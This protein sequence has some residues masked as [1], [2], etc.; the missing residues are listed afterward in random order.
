MIF[1]GLFLFTV[2]FF[3]IKI[4]QNKMQYEISALRKE[5]ND[6]KCM[7]DMLKSKMK[8]S[9]EYDNNMRNE[10]IE[11]RIEKLETM[12]YNYEYLAQIQEDVQKRLDIIYR[13]VKDDFARINQIIDSSKT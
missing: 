9:N 10:E 4:L 5:I 1:F 3:N 11:E 12:H 13:D 6:I 8:K 2:C 7:Q